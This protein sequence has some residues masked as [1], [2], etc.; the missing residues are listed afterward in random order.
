MSD[1]ELFRAIRELYHKDNFEI[2]FIANKKILYREENEHLLELYKKRENPLE[3]WHQIVRFVFEK[4]D[5][6]KFLTE[7]I[8][9]LL[10]SHYKKYT[11]YFEIKTETGKYALPDRFSDFVRLRTLF[12]KYFDIYKRILRRVNFDYPNNT[13]SETVVRGKINWSQTIKKSPFLFPIEFQTTNWIRKFETP[14][15]I[16]LVLY[17]FNIK[18]D[19]N[20][21]L[22]KKFVDSLNPDEID[23]V[24]QIV[25]GTNRIIATFPFRDVLKTAK[26]ISNYE[27]TSMHSQK[28][29]SQTK[30]RINSGKVRNKDYI[31]L[32]KW[33]DEYENLNIASIVTSKSK[34]QIKNLK[35][36]DKLFELWIFL[37]FLNYLKYVKRK[38]VKIKHD[39]SEVHLSFKH[40]NKEIKFIWGKKFPKYEENEP[41]HENTAWVRTADPD[42]VV[43][44][45]NRLLA[46]FDAKNYS[47]KTSR[48]EDFERCEKIHQLVLKIEKNRRRL[49]QHPENSQKLELQY[50]ELLESLAKFDPEGF[51]E[52]RASNNPVMAMEKL[53][54]IKESNEKKL[55]KFSGL[56]EEDRNS[57][58]AKETSAFHT[59]IYYMLNLDVN[60]GALI[61]SN[62]SASE[63]NQYEYPKE[64]QT[65][66]FIKCKVKFRFEH[67]RLKKDNDKNSIEERKNT[68]KRM[69]EVIEELL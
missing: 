25:E 48:E 50:D 17:A 47:K 23:K 9:K 46:V 35:D 13:F 58:Q 28:I 45:E 10:W 67:F 5:E 16:L 29:I 53:Q 20:K 54:N 11:D 31:D 37:E 61:F 59:M 68:F 63:E 18:N 56:N 38:D 64:N 52:F 1:Q 43:M 55:H 65:P 40:K 36:I 69:F 30:H 49:E 21:I 32:I 6:R 4:T 24:Q 51:L 60:Y 26:S 8:M 33:I 14:E 66:K 39:G 19:C 62:H 42:F 2:D 22:S 34:Y 41:E 57:I 3:K 7:Q 15:N 27:R 44:C 12:Q